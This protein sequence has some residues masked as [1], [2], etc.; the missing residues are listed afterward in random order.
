MQKKRKT[1]YDALLEKS[2]SIQTYHSILMLLHWDQETYMPP[3]GIQNRAEQIAQL[4][5]L[6]HEEKTSNYY[7]TMLGKLVHLNSGKLKDDIR[8]KAE[9]A[10]IREWHK[11]FQ[12]QDKLPVLFVK[13]FSQ[14]TSEATQIWTTAKKENNFKLFAPFLERIIQMNREKAD[15][16]G[17]T[18]HPYDALLET[19]EP[20]MTSA[21]VSNIFE[22]LQKELVPLLKKITNKKSPDRYFLQQQVHNDKQREIGEWIAAA[23]PCDADHTR[24]DVSSHPFSI[25]LHPHDSR[26]TTRFLP[27]NFMSNIFSVLHEAGHSMY[28]MGLPLQHYGTPLCQAASLSVHESQSRWWET[29]IGRSL[30]FWEYFYPQLQKKIPD[31]LRN[32][33]LS[34]FYKAIHHVAPTFIRVEADEVTYCLHVILRFEI[35][36]ELIAGKLSVHDLPEA[37]NA[38]FMELFGITPPNIAQGCLQDIHWSMGEFGYFPTYALG[39][40]LAGHL[41]TAFEKQ[42]PDWPKRVSNGDL[43]FIRTWLQENVHQWGRMYNYNEIGKKATGKTV[44]E[45][46][47][48]QY[49]KKKYGAIYGL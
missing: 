11:D 25:A 34:E 41:F 46:A 26:I 9:R 32:V 13:A 35:E 21:K 14:L 19:H 37:W 31:L 3:G 40:I 27:S 39:N 1:P 24:L 6:I 20:C 22:G 23:M 44:N 15:I 48:C 47:Y 16:L 10:I 30:P 43:L 12:R 2:K 4:A 38:K 36:K 28:E 8:G 33:S 18:D 5:S 42:H 17:F 7:K 49:L 45:T 29:F